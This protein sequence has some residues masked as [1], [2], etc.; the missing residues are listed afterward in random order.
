[1][2]F[3]PFFPWFVLGLWGKARPACCGLASLWPHHS[4]SAVLPVNHCWSVWGGCGALQ[5]HPAVSA[6]AGS[7]QQAGNC[8]GNTLCC[9][10]FVSCIHLYAILNVQCSLVFYLLFAFQAQQLITI[11]KEYIVGLAM[12][13]ERKKL[14]KDTLEDQ[15]RLCEVNICFGL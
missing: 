14:P 15:K 4:S 3:I 7:R 11:C 13:I 10:P 2:I 9:Y 6:A 8:R 12:E 1:M 5:I